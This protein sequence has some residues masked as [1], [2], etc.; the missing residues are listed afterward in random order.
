MELIGKTDFTFNAFHRRPLYMFASAGNATI[1][2]SDID[3]S[4]IIHQQ[5][6]RLIH[7]SLENNEYFIATTTVQQQST[8]SSRFQ[9][10]KVRCRFMAN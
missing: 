1:L 7:T 8:C 10:L 3:I 5:T 9:R 6:R 4:T 2:G